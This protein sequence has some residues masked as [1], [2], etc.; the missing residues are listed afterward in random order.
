M[1]RCVNT[2]ILLGNCGKDPEIRYTASGKAV[3]KLSVAV[4]E[5]FKDSRGEWQ[6]RIG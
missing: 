6:E 2:V 1:S 4:N 3:A 5:S